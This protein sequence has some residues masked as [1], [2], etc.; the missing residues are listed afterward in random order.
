[1][2]GYFVF[3]F[4]FPKNGVGRA[5]ENVN[6]VN[7]MKHFM[8]WCNDLLNELQNLVYVKSDPN[9]YDCTET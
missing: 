7:K 8:L 3:K 5:M 4:A 2:E 1:M 6:N 9:T